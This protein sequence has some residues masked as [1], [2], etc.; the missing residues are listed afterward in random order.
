VV[1]VVII[2]AAGGN[3]RPVQKLSPVQAILKAPF[4]SKRGAFIGKASK[5]EKFLRGQASFMI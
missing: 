3:I 5:S 4:Q 1:V 2:G